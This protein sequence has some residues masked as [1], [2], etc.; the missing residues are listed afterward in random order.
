MFSAENIKGVF[1]LAAARAKTTEDVN[2]IS[3]RNAVDFGIP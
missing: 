3:R 2:Y 1:N